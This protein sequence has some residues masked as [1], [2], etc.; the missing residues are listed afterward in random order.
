MVELGHPGAQRDFLGSDWGLKTPWKSSFLAGNHEEC[1]AREIG[2][3]RALGAAY[4]M[5]KSKLY[6]G[7]L[8][9]NL[10]QSTQAELIG[11]DYAATE[12][13]LLEHGASRAALKA[14][15][16]SHPHLFTD[17]GWW[18]DLVEVPD[19]EVCKDE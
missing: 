4:G 15:K 19:W 13:R 10:I 18:R 9:E 17:Q 16:R 6:G 14:I 1:M 2:K 7:S 8:V 12:K 11:A 3:K 5:G